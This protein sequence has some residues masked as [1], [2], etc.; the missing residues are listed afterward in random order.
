MRRDRGVLTRRGDTRAGEVTAASLAKAVA[1]FKD[2]T[3][4]FKSLR[5]Q[6]GD[7]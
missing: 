7:D 3:L 5:D 6:D 4:T 2:N 1:D